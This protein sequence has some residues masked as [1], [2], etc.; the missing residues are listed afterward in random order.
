MPKS[1]V[2]SAPQPAEPSPVATFEE[3]LGELEALVAKMEGGELTLDESLH[4]FE[5]GI[6][7]YRTCHAAL[8]QAEARVKLLADPEQPETAR[9]LAADNPP[10]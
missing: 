2:K 4:S 8:E 7:L 3:S 10:D 1:T 6:T 5:R 9:P